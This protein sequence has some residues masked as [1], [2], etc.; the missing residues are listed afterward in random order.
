[1]LYYMSSL[2]ESREARSLLLR[3]VLKQFVRLVLYKLFLYFDISKRHKFGMAMSQ[4]AWKVEQAIG[5]GDNATTI[6]DVINP[7]LKPKWGDL[8]ETMKALVWVGKNTVEVSKNRPQPHDL[9]KS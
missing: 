7:G 4:V 3:A 2:L 5:H 1:M 6:Q 8:N 9:D